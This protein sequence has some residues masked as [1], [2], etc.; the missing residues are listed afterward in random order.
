MCLFIIPS[1]SPY[2][3]IAASVDAKTCSK[4]TVKCSAD[5]NDRDHD[6]GCL[7]PYNK[8]STNSTE[9]IGVTSS[10]IHAG[11]PLL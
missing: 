6:N 3:Y 1:K 9:P 10:S 4:L 8:T 7:P 11:S 2:A 5:N